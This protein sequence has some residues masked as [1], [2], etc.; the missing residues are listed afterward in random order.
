[1]T[2]DEMRGQFR[3]IARRLGQI[4]SVLREEYHIESRIEHIV[5]RLRSLELQIDTLSRN[6]SGL[7]EDIAGNPAGRRPPEGERK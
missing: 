5:E 4:E 2:E 6:L 1:M 3:D 7:R